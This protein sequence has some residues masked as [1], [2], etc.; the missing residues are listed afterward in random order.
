MTKTSAT[1]P[2][3]ENDSQYYAGQYGPLQNTSG[4]DQTVFSFP[5]LNTTL[6]SN[7]DGFSNQV[8]DTGNFT[9]H[10]LA[11][12]TT[13]PS[14]ANEIP[15]ENVVVTD[16]TNN[17]ILLRNIQGSAVPNN[18]FIFLQLTDIARG[19]NWGSYS[20]LTLNEIIDNWLMSYVGEDKII[21]KIKR[22][23]V[24]FHAR[25][26]MQ[27][28]SYDT[29]KSYKSQELTV[30]TNLTVPI[31]RDY[32]NY[33]RLAFAD[34]SGVLRTIQPLS[35]LS[36]NPTEMPIQDGATGIPSQSSYDTNLEASQSLI[37]DRWNR[38]NKNDI[39]GNY[40]PFQSDGVFDAAWYKTAYG[41]RYG[42]DPV[43]S[44]QN[45]WFSISQRTG[46]F[47]FSSNLVNQ[48]V[49]LSYISDGLSYT[50]NSI[51]PKL[52]EEAI[53][54][55][56]ASRV[57]QLRRDVDGGTKQVFKRDSYVKTR[58]A[59]IRLQNLKLDEIT[60]WFRGQSKWIKH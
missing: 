5:N 31:P 46:T 52:V 44:N 32:V 54:A 16:T 30:P 59:K 23:D 43:V 57:F 55:Q 29:L 27:E 53:Y 41:Q 56:I 51:V 21:Q 60:Q 8:R 42:L 1:I 12:S 20:Y 14:T 40:T 39:T 24:L 28:L 49:F 50:L 34:G 36:G 45:G 33:T 37:E 19:D 3:T 9:L 13:I 26:A 48:V 4:A 22:G 6:V 10:L 18:Q 2:I 25:R 11:T 7:Y 17:T 58:N 15:V 35:G 47:N 38:A